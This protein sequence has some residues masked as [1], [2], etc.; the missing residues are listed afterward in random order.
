MVLNL[1]GNCNYNR[2]QVKR[3]KL[4]GVWKR[5]HKEKLHDLYSSP[6]ITGVIKSRKMRWARHVACMRE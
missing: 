1:P 6:N 4:K 5:L 3:V 2:N